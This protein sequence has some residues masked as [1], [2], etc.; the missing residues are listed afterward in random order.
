MNTEILQ[1][2]ESKGDIQV[3]PKPATRA[4]DIIPIRGQEADASLW[5]LSEQN[6]IFTSKDRGALGVLLRTRIVCSLERSPRPLNLPLF[7]WQQDSNH[8]HPVLGQCALA[9]VW[10]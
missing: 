7:C 1:N 4:R 2:D 3:R 5:K 8:R 9:E 10:L 6:E